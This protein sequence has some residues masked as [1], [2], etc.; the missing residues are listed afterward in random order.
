MKRFFDFVVSLIAIILLLPVFL[1]ISI[2]IIATSKGGPFYLQTRVGRYGK[3]FKIIKF[4]TMYKKS[5]QKGLLTVGMRDPRITPVGFFLRKTKLDELP[6]LFN[7]LLGHMSFV[8]PRPE[9]P[10]Y[11]EL[12]TEKQKKILTVRPGLTDYASL[13]YIHENKILAQAE[14]PEKFYIEQIMPAKLELSLQYI[15]D[16]NLITDF[17]IIWKTIKQILNNDNA[18]V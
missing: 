8:G 11:V 12:Y 16:Q 13:A 3:L 10:K 2:L 1:I 6:Q 15:H 17:K 7:I 5:D 14:D 18:Q 4:R 9:V